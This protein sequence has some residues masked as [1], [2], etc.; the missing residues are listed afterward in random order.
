LDD[1]G[2][3]EAHLTNTRRRKQNERAIE[4]GNA[5]N[6]LREYG[7]LQLSHGCSQP[8]KSNRISCHNLG[9]IRN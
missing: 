9:G 8:D 7:S 1:L 4:D 6:E 3:E 2:V 5:D